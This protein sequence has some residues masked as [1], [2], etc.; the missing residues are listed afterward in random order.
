MIIYG[1]WTIEFGLLEYSVL[2]RKVHPCVD[3]Q[4]YEQE[5]KNSQNKQKSTSC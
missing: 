4:T 1:K 5:H 3:V 2:P